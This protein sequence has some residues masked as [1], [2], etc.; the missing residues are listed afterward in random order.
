M[1]DAPR[2]TY[3]ATCAVS[4]MMMIMADKTLVRRACRA[5]RRDFA[6]P[7]S[8]AGRIGGSAVRLVQGAIDGVRSADDLVK[9]PVR[10]RSNI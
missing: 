8:E 6:A 1:H 7:G 9:S 5:G 10:V 2:R 3:D 4:E